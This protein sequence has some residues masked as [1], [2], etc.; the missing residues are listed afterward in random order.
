MQSRCVADHP[1]PPHLFFSLGRRRMVGLGSVAGGVAKMGVV[2]SK[3]EPE[4]RHER[5]PTIS[6]SSV[7]RWASKIL[8]R[9][10]SMHCNTRMPSRVDFSWLNSGGMSGAATTSSSTSAASP[11]SPSSPPSPVG[12]DSPAC[13]SAAPPSPPASATPSPAGAAA[14]GSCSNG[15]VGGKSDHR[16][17]RAPLSRSMHVSINTRAQFSCNLTWPPPDVL[18]PSPPSLLPATLGAL[19]ASGDP[20]ASAGSS[21][22]A[23]ASSA[24]GAAASG[25]STGAAAA[26]ASTGGAS[27][28]PSAIVRR[29]DSDDDTDG[30]LVLRGGNRAAVW[31]RFGQKG[32]PSSAPVSSATFAEV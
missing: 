5:W 17:T 23:A 21:A 10:H 31:F 9:S 12:D 6:V 29:R 30:R 32:K 16:V 28:S 26:S 11:P 20:P 18:P 8:S 15:S 4:S 1:L 14:P 27:P 25:S 22:G 2:W 24:G 3:F 7:P 19:P 13:A